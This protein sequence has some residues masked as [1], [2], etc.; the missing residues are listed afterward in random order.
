MSMAYFGLEL[1]FSIEV[2]LTVPI[3]LKLQ[4]PESIYSYVY[5]PSPVFAFLF[6]PLMGLMSDRCES[7]FGRRKPFI[8]VLSL[9]AFIGISLILN[10]GQVGQWFNDDSE[11]IK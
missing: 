6:Q 10:G 4:V 9:G 8:L 1:L 11:V 5:F 2:A 3:L 7:K